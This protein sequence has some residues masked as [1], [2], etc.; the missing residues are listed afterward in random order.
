MTNHK[1]LKENPLNAAIYALRNEIK[2]VQDT[3]VELLI[4][5]V[6]ARYEVPGIDRDSEL[7]DVRSKKWQCDQSEVGCYMA[8]DIIKDQIKT[9]LIESEQ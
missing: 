3:R 8:I 1:K 6:C 9:D 4:R 7:S 5:E 2:S